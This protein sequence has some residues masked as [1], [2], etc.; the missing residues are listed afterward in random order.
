M[1]DDK[2]EDRLRDAANEYNLPPETPRDAMWMAITANRTA[3]MTRAKGGRRPL[4]WYGLAAAA[5]LV[6]GILIG[7]GWQKSAGRSSGADVAQQPDTT[8]PSG[9]TD[10]AYH[11]AAVQYLGETEEFLTSFRADLKHGGV[12]SASTERARN[13]LSSNRLLMD[14]PAGQDPKIK[15]LLEDLELVL[16]EISQ[17]TNTRSARDEAGFIDQGLEKSGILSRINSAVPAGQTPVGL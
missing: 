8:T 11:I 3:R 4:L 12:D 14:S 1:M 5:V 13:L 9:S 2:L 17:L 10:R 15:P 6:L 7:R 16:A